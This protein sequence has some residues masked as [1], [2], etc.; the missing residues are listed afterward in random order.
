MAL[1]LLLGSRVRSSRFAITYR[2]VRPGEHV[3]YDVIADQY[4]G[5]DDNV[6]AA[7]GR[8]HAAPESS[9][10]RAMR[11]ALAE[12][13]L[14]VE[15][16]G[17]DEARLRGFLE[18]TAE[19]MPDTLYVTLMP[20]LA[21]NLACSYCFQKDHPA[22]TR[23][24][25]ATEEATMRWVIDRLDAS[26]CKKLLVHFFGG[27]PLTR[28]DALLRTAE[29]FSKALRERG[30]QFAWEMTTNGVGLTAD[31]AARLGSFGEGAL[32]VTLDGD[33]ETHDAVRVFRNGKGTFEEILANALA[34]ARSCP[35]VKLRIGGNFRPEQAASYERL[36]DRLEREGLAGRLDRLRFKPVVDT[37]STCTSCASVDAENDTTLRL[38]DSARRRGLAPARERLTP[39][40]PCE[41]HWKNAFVIDPEGRLYKCPAV[42][43]RPELAVGSVESQAV[44][45]APLIEAR[46]WEQCGACP[47][48]PVCM[49]GCLGGQYLQSG[50][51][52]QVFCRKA[53]FQIAFRQEVRERYLAEFPEPFHPGTA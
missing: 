16:D 7:L 50:R 42:A 36:L 33:R 22:F 6:L 26:G 20:T 9:E 25:L 11:E 37:D 15:D 52:D 31:F 18:R 27:E 10:E 3:L 51:T 8:L 5:I 21:C 14:L 1:A 34:I 43:G 2:N 17:A 38:A 44:K 40:G 24:S 35:N 46:P 53:Y 13:G 23:M 41:L 32:K 30:G 47:F 19:G 45:T 48:L 4:V 12:A 39:S 29:A 28:K 49:G